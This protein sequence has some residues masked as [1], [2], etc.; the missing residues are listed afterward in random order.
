MART[1]AEIYESSQDELIRGFIDGLKEQ[2]QL[3]DVMLAAALQTDRDTIKFN[4]VTDEPDTVL[5]DCST[6]LTYDGMDTSP[7]SIALCTHVTPYKLCSIGNDLGSA[8]VDQWDAETQAAIRSHVKKIASLIVNGSASTDCISGL[9]SQTS[10]EVS[11]TAT[12]FGLTDLEAMEDAVL[13]GGQK[14]FIG[15]PAT[16]RAVRAEVELAGEITVSELEGMRNPLRGWGGMPFIKTVHAPAN[17]LFLVSLDSFKL[18]FGTVKNVA[19]GDINIEG[20]FGVQKVGHDKDTM[21]ILARLVSHSTVALYDLQGSAY[22][23]LA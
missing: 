1:L 12:A 21:N 16:I 9:N 3:V 6:E 11:L 22:L 8:F 18:W 19:A 10:K 15:A 4:R 13:A 20:L 17:R 5:A 14:V 7:V 23:D 2:D